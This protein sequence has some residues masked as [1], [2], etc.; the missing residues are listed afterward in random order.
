MLDDDEFQD[1]LA[2]LN[3]IVWGRN[4]STGRSMSIPRRRDRAE[5]LADVVGAEIVDPIRTALESLSELVSSALG[6]L[7]EI[8]S[9]ADDLREAESG[10]ERE[11]AYTGLDEQLNSVRNTLEEMGVDVTDTWKPKGK[12]KD[13]TVGDLTA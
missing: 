7:D 2:C 5:E 4:P 11:D 6:E 8:E 1:G 13:K 9:T 10:D 3:H 12:G